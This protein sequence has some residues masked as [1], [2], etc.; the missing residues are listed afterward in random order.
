M[1][2]KYNKR[3]EHAAIVMNEV[4]ISPHL[5]CSFSDRWGR[6]R[7]HSMEKRLGKPALWG[8]L[9]GTR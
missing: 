5:S 1:H 8:R 3:L 6:S 4:L 2:L 7:T 9:T